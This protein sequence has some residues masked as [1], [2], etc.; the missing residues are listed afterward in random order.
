ME[1]SQA[2]LNFAK[3]IRIQMNGERLDDQSCQLLG[4][5][6]QPLE[7]GCPIVLDYHNDTARCDIRLGDEWRVNPTD[8]QLLQLRYEFGE[9][10]VELVFG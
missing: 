10:A 5:L 1:I 9:Q 7:G 8:D 2:R 3:S 6:L 4:Q